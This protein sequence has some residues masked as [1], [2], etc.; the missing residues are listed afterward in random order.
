MEKNIQFHY[1]KES[2]K[3]KREVRNDLKGKIKKKTGNLKSVTVFFK[4]PVISFSAY[5]AEV[6]LLK[7]TE[8]YPPK[9]S[10]IRF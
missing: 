1:Q 7:S 4:F 9:L 10:N 5:I 8:D 3:E 2:G 6:F